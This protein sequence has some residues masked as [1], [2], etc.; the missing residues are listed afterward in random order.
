M[1]TTTHVGAVDGGPQRDQDVAGQSTGRRGGDA[2]EPEGEADH[3]VDEGRR[4]AQGHG[5][6]DGNDHDGHAEGVATHRSSAVQVEGSPRRQ[7]H[8]WPRREF[9]RG[10][11]PEGESGE[12]RPTALQRHQP[13]QHEGGH[14]HVVTPGGEGQ[15]GGGQHGEELQ[16]ADAGVRRGS[17]AAR[18]R[19]G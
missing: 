1:P 4:V 6:D 18:A 7:H 10:R 2:G 8:Q 3:V 11:R 15:G 9:E 16:G 13:E 12:Q 17:D 14:G 5:D 19:S